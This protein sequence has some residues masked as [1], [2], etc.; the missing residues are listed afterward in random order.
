MELPAS[1]FDPKIPCRNDD[2]YT[3][4]P[5]WDTYSHDSKKHISKNKI[6][7]FG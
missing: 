3:T 5:L 2:H 6:K 1:S 4:V 7:L